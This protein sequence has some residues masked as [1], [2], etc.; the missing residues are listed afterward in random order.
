MAAAPPARSAVGAAAPHSAP[1]SPSHPAPTVLPLTAPRHRPRTQHPPA[2]PSQRPAIALAPSAHRPSPH[3]A[4][5]SHPAPTVLPPTAPRHRP[6]TQ[7]P[8][9]ASL[10]ALRHRPRNPHH[11]LASPTPGRKSGNQLH[12]GYLVTVIK[13]KKK[14]LRRNHRGSTFLRPVLENLPGFRQPLSQM[15]YAETVPLEETATPIHHTAQ[16]SRCRLFQKSSM[17]GHTS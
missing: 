11:L 5:P 4:P 6:R 12:S 17:G 16:R 14:K 9:S 3:S 2:F 13:K 1:P 10:T 8:P 7:R 15:F